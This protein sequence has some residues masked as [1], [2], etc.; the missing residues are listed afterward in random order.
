MT[1]HHIFRSVILGPTHRWQITPFDLKFDAKWANRPG[2]VVLMSPTETISVSVVDRQ[3]TLNGMW[4][5]TGLEWVA[6]ASGKKLKIGVTTK[7][8]SKSC[9]YRTGYIP[10]NVAHSGFYFVEAD[11]KPSTFFF[12]YTLP[13]GLEAHTHHIIIEPQSDDITIEILDAKIEVL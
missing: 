1:P 11:T 13:E 2:S 3:K 4:F 7:T 8:E 6:F 10:Q 12:E 9:T 5:S